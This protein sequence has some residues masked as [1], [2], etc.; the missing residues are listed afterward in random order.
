MPSIQRMRGSLL[1]KGQERHS[2]CF[3]AFHR[4]LT[5]KPLVER[6]IRPP[7]RDPALRRLPHGLQERRGVGGVGLR[8]GAALIH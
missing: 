5:L 1:L 3:Y 7:L 2:L 6:E 8:A 4:L